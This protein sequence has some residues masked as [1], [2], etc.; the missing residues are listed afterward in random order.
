MCAVRVPVLQVLE[1]LN[2]EVRAALVCW[3]LELVLQQPALLGPEV[4]ALLV[5]ALL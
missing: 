4:S 3:L 2:P 1:L 5:R